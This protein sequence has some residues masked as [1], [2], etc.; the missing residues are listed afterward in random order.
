MAYSRRSM[1]RFGGAMLAAAAAPSA[2]SLERS[3]LRADNPEFYAPGTFQPF[4]NT[5]F[6]VESPDVHAWLTLLTID[7][8]KPAPAQSPRGAVLGPQTETA[9][10][11]F[12][13]SGDELAQ[14]TYE[15]SHPD[16]GRF[17]LFLVPAGT[18]RYAAT[19]NR[20]TS[21]DSVP[22]APARR[23]R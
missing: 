7:P 16:L 23:R 10:L 11:H 20:L 17:Q 22:P 2:M 14:D 18:F 19:L 8:C 12:A 9:I 13:A 4:V 15:L 6:K 3:S 5:G 21:R 1:F